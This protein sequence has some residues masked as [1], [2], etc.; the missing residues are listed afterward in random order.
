MPIV[1]AVRLLICRYRKSALSALGR[2]D[3]PGP[4]RTK[5][6]LLVDVLLCVN[7]EL[8]ERPGLYFNRFGESTS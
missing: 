8:A 2:W 6:R 7:Q 3:L 5:N 1:Y 4:L